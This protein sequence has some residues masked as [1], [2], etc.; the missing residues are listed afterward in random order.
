MNYSWKVIDHEIL[1]QGYF[2][3][4][5]FHLQHEKYEGGWTEVFQRELF[6]RGSAVAVLLFDPFLDK[7]V[8][9][10]QFRV[11]GVGTLDKPW[12]KEIVAGIIEQ[13]E[14]DHEVAKRE[15]VEEAGCEILKM[16]KITQFYVSPG[17]T[18]EQCIVYCGMVDSVGVGGVF[19]LEHE[20]EDIRVEVVSILQAEAWLKDGTINSAA[21]IIALQWLLLNKSW[22]QK[23]WCQKD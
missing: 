10:E 2:R 13:G 6:E 3:M 7:V 22:L 15:S 14:S 19:G 16:E 9:I 1:F 5:K 18:T 20:F 4:E 12:M 11:G 17:G 21:S 8:L 23:K